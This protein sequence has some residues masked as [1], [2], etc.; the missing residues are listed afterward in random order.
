MYT[1]NLAFDTFIMILYWGR[2]TSNSF[3]C[4]MRTWKSSY[5]CIVMS[6]DWH[7]Y[8][9]LSNNDNIISDN[10]IVLKSLTIH[11]QPCSFLLL[12]K[13]LCLW[14]LPNQ[15]PQKRNHDFTERY[16]NIREGTYK[17]MRIGYIL[18]KNRFFAVHQRF[19]I[20]ARH[21]MT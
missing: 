8:N 13:I 12:C 7:G 3:C 17:P 20:R 6:M 9:R 2:Y 10:N 16:H 11:Q 15:C 1:K 4:I 21:I 14:R 5:W 18:N 19:R